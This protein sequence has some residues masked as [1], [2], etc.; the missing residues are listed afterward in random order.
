[1]PRISNKTKSSELPTL[2]DCALH[3]LVDEILERIPEGM[4]RA[5]ALAAIGRKVAV[6]LSF[7]HSSRR[8]AAE[9]CE[10]LAR[11]IRR[12]ECIPV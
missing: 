11:Q 8:A 3:S 5:S 7:E 1:M 2:S 4:S 9:V 12:G 6:E 10:D